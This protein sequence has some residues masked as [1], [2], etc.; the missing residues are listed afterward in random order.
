MLLKR[1]WTLTVLCV[2]Y[3]GTRLGGN[4]SLWARMHLAWGI[5]HQ[6]PIS[7]ETSPSS[8]GGAGQRLP[9]P[10]ACPSFCLNL[11]APSGGLGVCSAVYL[12]GC[13]CWDPPPCGPIMQ[14]PRLFPKSQVSGD[15]CTCLKDRISYSFQASSGLGGAW[16][17]PPRWLDGCVG[18]GEALPLPRKPESGGL[19]A[20]WARSPVSVC[21][22]VGS[23]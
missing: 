17:G 4:Y 16:T 14:K 12:A 15:F 13:T 3:W 19:L 22:R 23:F 20:S 1:F 5:A 18:T 10:G 9:I 2:Y 21:S 6:A 8:N 7:I 11:Q